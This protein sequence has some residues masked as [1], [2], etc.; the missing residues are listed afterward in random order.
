MSLE[1]STQ[2]MQAHIADGIGWMTF[3]NPARHN[4]LS[5]EM[6]QGIGDILEHFA[7]NDEVRV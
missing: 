5:L 1:L 2:R 4:A 3:N 6:W 7:G